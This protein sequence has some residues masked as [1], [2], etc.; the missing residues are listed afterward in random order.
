MRIPNVVGTAIGK[1]H[2]VPCIILFICSKQKDMRSKV[3]KIV[4]GY[5]VLMKETTP[6]QSRS[7]TEN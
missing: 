4:E 2:G 1:E 6:F 7:V 3:P 5:R